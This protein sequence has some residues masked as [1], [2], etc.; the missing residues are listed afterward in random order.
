MRS[1]RWLPK[2][3]RFLLSACMA[4]LC[5]AHAEVQSVTVVS[6]ASLDYFDPGAAETRR[7]FSNEVI[8]ESNAGTRVN[9]APPDLQFYEGSFSK[10]ATVAVNGEMLFLQATMHQCDDSSNIS[11]S[12]WVTV[13]SSRTGDW[14][15]I[16][17]KEIGLH[18]GIFRTNPGLDT[19]DASVVLPAVGDGV[20]SVTLED[21]ISATVNACEGGAVD[22]WLLIDPQGI[23]FDSDTNKPV[24]GTVITLIDL[25]G[26][27]NGGKPGQPATVFNHDLTPAPSTI[28]TDATGHYE[29]P[30]VA[31]SSY[32]LDVK[33]PGD[34]TFPSKK[35][36]SQ[37]HADLLE[38]TYRTIHETGSQG[39][40]FDVTI[41]L[42]IVIFDIPLDGTPNGLFAQKVAS[43]SRAGVAETIEYTVQIQNV[44]GVPVRDVTV[45]DKLPAGFT[46]VPG[47][48]RLDNAL[49]A[50]PTGGKGPALTFSI[51]PLDGNATRVLTYRTLI[52]PGALQGDGINRAQVFAAA[53]GFKQS[54][55]ATTHVEVDAGPFSADSYILGK[56]YADCDKNRVQDADEPGIPGVRLFMED[57][58]SVVTDANGKYSLYGIKPRTHVLKADRSTL[59]MGAELEALAH[60]NAG[61]GNTLFVDSRPGELHRADF[62]LRGCSLSTISTI[63]SRREDARSYEQLARDLSQELKADET[64]AIGDVRSLPA[65]GT[66]GAQGA[67]STASG[68]G[69][70]TSPAKA[71]EATLESLLPSLDPTPD[72]VG[73]RDGATLS[74]TQIKVRVK[75]Y[76][77]LPLDLVVNDETVSE[78][79][80]GKK[81]TSTDSQVE[82]REY[83]GVDLQAGENTLEVVA[84]DSF[85]NERS[86]K[87]IRVMAP[88]ALARVA[89]E[90]ASE[91]VAADGESLMRLRIMLKDRNGLRVPVR[92]PITLD[93]SDGELRVQDLDANLPGLQTMIEDGVLELSLQAPA[94]P[95]TVNV[96]AQVSK[97]TGKLALDFAPAL[98]PMVA[99]GV[100]EGGVS[101]RK[102]DPSKL[103]PARNDDGFEQELTD[104]SNSDG[105]TSPG[106]RAALFLKGKV[107]G[108]YLLTLSYDSDKDGRQRL[109]RDIQPDKYYPVYGDGSVKGYDAQSTGHLYVR[110]DKNKSYL[111]AGDMTTQ[112]ISQARTLGAY[113]RNLTGVKEHYSR[114][115]HTVEMFASHASERQIVQEIPA[116]GTS[117]PYEL[118]SGNAVENSERVEIITRDRNQPALVIETTTL[119]RFSDYEIEPFTGRL[120]LRGPVPSLDANL[121]PRFIR[122]TYEV[123]AGGEEYWTAGIDSQIHVTDSLS[124]GAAMVDDRN[125]LDGTKLASTNATLK[126]S[127]NT[128]FVAEAARIDRELTGTGWG[129]RVEMQHAGDTLRARAFAGRTDETFNNPAAFL[130]NGRTEAGA[131]ASYSFNERT[132]L[133]G[134]ALF[135]EDVTN[136]DRRQGGL[137]GLERSFAENRK[138]E[139]GA[140]RVH[141]D[142]SALSQ[143]DTDITSLR[144]KLSSPI[145]YLSNVS[146]FGEYEQ[147]VQDMDRRMAAVGGDYAFQNRSRVYL[148]HEFITSLSGPYALDSTQ[149]RNTTVLGLD[150]RYMQDDRVFSEYR[151]G[152]S[153]GARES[154]AAIGLRNNWRIAEGM[155]ASTTLERVETL[156]GPGT[157]ETAAVTGAVEYTRN[158]SWKGT[159]R[160]ELRSGQTS[161]GLLSTFGVARKVSDEWTFLGRNVYAVTNYSAQEDRT[162]ERAQLGLA[163]R[164]GN[165]NRMNALMRYEFRYEDNAAESGMRRQSHVISGHINEQFG[166]AFVLS[167]QYAAKLVTEA[168][169]AQ[170]LDN[171]AQMVGVRA[172][173]DFGR[174]WDLGLTARSLF[175]DGFDTRQ[176]SMGAELGFLAAKNLWISGGYNVTGFH[177]QELSAGEYTN[178]GIYLRLRLKFDESVIDPSLLDKKAGK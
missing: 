92:M 54:N 110:V 154:E 151:I 72:F 43:R 13:A 28:T 56:V 155:R 9:P 16:E 26:R 58:T 60:R 135:S 22:D 106:A 119:G 146:A 88:G 51:P 111:L 124:F 21:T 15:T 1:H 83:I 42:G 71:T 101:F 139:L 5:V 38:G 6:Q 37:A 53:P 144:T 35:V 138:L 167:S 150:T 4:A 20:L 87:T 130:G 96:S 29:F 32:K 3:A 129:R 40:D 82:L 24:A 125:P 68:S 7:I 55:L 45:Q 128:T 91:M 65:S 143:E 80:V 69:S 158:P 49:L 134:E 178:R 74:A 81:L 62:A 46:Y 169:D 57:G 170:D 64:A 12:G 77:G 108:D 159:A 14:E 121:N 61:D 90:P 86:R 166:R 103:E 66:I 41:D 153:L 34:Y 63:E 173:R 39:A 141:L 175:T 116:N 36:K 73:L 113:N 132:N 8:A 148:R 137:L 161:D 165:T 149:R 102:L 18:T 19:E 67:A 109:F 84:H 75:G 52:G 157:N 156:T 123:D 25:D 131:K 105:K 76:A 107:R 133:I 145:P 99:A 94:R 172:T 48:A 97:L 33:P 50:D 136:G 163:Y 47:S 70:R 117:G 79:R 59:P 95:G 160:M 164:D 112:S 85:G 177:D 114:G 120:L 93:A 17:A 98:R 126:L 122:V 176:D 127:D 11:E 30:L 168:F 78:K 152:N 2:A 44:S 118:S 104:L 140:R 142:P 27:G 31:E 115:G 147:D 10:Q 171:T 100:V 89:I 23:V 174:R 162:Q